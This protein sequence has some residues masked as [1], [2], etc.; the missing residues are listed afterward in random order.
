MKIS[1]LLIE[2]FKGVKSQ[3]ISFIPE[4]DGTP[5][6]LKA[7]IGDNG[8]GKTTILQAIALTLSLA[9]RKIQNI[10]DFGW[11]GF[12]PE[13]IASLGSTH[14]EMDILFDADELKITDEL[15]NIW[16]N[17]LN[18][19]FLNSHTLV[20]PGNEEH[21]QLTYDSGTVSCSKGMAGLVQFWGRF[22]IKMLAK[23]MPWV[24][25]K[26]SGVGDVF[27]FDQYRNLGSLHIGKA[28]D[29][30]DNGYRAENWN[31]GVEQLREYLVGWWGYHTSPEKN[32][33]KDL[34]AELEKNFSILFPGTRFRG[35]KPKETDFNSRVSDFYFLLERD[36]K[37]FDLAEMSSGEQAIFPLLYEF[38]RL[39]ISKSI[40]LI[41]EL[42]LHL[43][44]PQQQALL[45]ALP[46]LGKDCQFVITTHSPYLEGVIP[47]EHEVR[48]QGGR[49]CL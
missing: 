17:S 33:G 8:S 36:G 48:L 27:W 47:D 46:K 2:N 24:K 6:P 4:Y 37:I 7:L 23:T 18:H 49:L 35:I 5:R 10:S 22:Y 38:V 44:P 43:H 25:D 16:K 31:S 28:D 26:F 13:R 42:E 34:L 30:S 14:I 39:S 32:A 40:V 45:A 15:F 29:G 21:V 19:E 3:E 12:M 41:D 11:H 1:G 20:A 9:T